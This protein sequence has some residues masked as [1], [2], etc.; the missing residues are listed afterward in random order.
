[1]ITNPHSE[2][3]T[4]ATLF[5]L[6]CACVLTCMFVYVFMCMH[7]SLCAEI[8]MNV[9][10]HTRRGQRTTSGIVP[11]QLFI[12]NFEISPLTGTWDPEGSASWPSVHTDPNISASP[13]LRSQA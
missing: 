9:C 11:Q 7:V 5:E 10:A 3:F 12:L 4:N 8:H 1:M 13:V 6:V 2:Y